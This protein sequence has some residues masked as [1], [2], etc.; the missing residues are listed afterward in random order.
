MF[1]IL[2]IKILQ[3]I[4]NNTFSGYI[5]FTFLVRCKWQR[6]NKTQEKKRYFAISEDDPKVYRCTSKNLN[7]QNLAT[8][9]CSDQALIG[10]GLICKIQ[11]GQNQTSNVPL[12]PSRPDHSHIMMDGCSLKEAPL[13]QR[14]LRV[15]PSPRP[16]V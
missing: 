14:L 15:K 4:C 7:D 5:H 6:T 1:I 2:A 8:D 16:Q 9:L 10:R 11:F 12:S 13:L 3:R